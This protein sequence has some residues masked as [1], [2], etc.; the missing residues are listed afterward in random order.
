MKCEEKIKCKRSV[1]VLLAATVYMYMYMS[2][3]MCIFV[4]VYRKKI[5]LL[6]NY[7]GHMPSMEEHLTLEQQVCTCICNAFLYQYDC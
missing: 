4:N 7:L 3:Y 6:N 5:D 1:H 2:F